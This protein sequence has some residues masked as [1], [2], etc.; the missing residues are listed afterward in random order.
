M[1][2]ATSGLRF[3]RGLVLRPVEQTTVAQGFRRPWRD[4]IGDVVGP[5]LH[6]LTCTPSRSPE[7]PRTKLIGHHAPPHFLFTS[8]VAV[9]DR[10]PLVGRIAANGEVVFMVAEFRT[11]CVVL[12][13]TMPCDGGDDSNA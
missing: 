12:L 13:E 11:I 1:N 10:M 5:L 9:H 7:R 3:T 2:V 8:S 6:V 4:P